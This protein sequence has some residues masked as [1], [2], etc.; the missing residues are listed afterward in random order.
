MEKDPVCGMDVDPAQAAVTT[1]HNGRMY[2]FCS[3]ECKEAFDA[4][5]GKYTQG[6]HAS[7]TP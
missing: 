6:E 4:D 5:P 7:K 1:L 2:Y 3:A